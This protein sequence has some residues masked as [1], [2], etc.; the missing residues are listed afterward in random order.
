[1]DYIKFYRFRDSIVVIVSFIVIDTGNVFAQQQQGTP[2]F[3]KDRFIS[4]AGVFYCKPS[5]L[6][7]KN[8]YLGLNFSP[9]LNLLNSYSDFSIAFGTQLDMGYKLSS[10]DNNSKFLA[11]IPAMA[12][13]NA[14]HL[15]TRDFFS[16]FGLFAGGGYDFC[17]ISGSTQKGFMW[18]GGMR[19]WIFR[20]SFTL[21]YTQLVLNDSKIVMNLFSLQLDLGAY[22]KSVYKNNV[23]SRF[24]KP[25]RK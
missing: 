8:S 13:I 24:V 2:N 6:P 10:A 12:T 25:M 4:S 16:R 9:Q 19:T 5:I 1:M 7:A 22:L 14:G 17:S 11:S 15:A 21:R 18:T 3:F 23:I 20:R